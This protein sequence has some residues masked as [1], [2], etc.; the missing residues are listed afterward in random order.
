MPTLNQRKT[1]RSGLQ[2][3]TGLYRLRFILSKKRI[4]SALS[5]IATADESFKNQGYEGEQLDFTNDIAALLL[6]A[7]DFDDEY[8]NALKHFVNQDPKAG[9]GL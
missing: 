5:D 8:F 4:L 9:R 7:R 6:A 1:F 2:T 3:P